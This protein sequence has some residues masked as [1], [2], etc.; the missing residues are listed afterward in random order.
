V[1]DSF[2]GM[3]RPRTP[4]FIGLE[5]AKAN[6]GPAFVLQTLMLMAVLAY[7]FHSPSKAALN[8]LADY[9]ERHGVAFVLGASV[10]VGAV[11]PEIFVVCV[12][13]TW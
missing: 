11:L 3:T 12:F 9:K 2:A 5:A 6:A 10:L 13:P 8:A 1:C 4:W 7:Y